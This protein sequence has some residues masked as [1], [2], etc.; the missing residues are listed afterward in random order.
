MQSVHILQYMLR[1]SNLILARRREVATERTYEHSVCVILEIQIST[2][3]IIA[4]ARS[5][6]TSLEPRMV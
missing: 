6:H 3:T 5:T 2:W 4:Y 1:R